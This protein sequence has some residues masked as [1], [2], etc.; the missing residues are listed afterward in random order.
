[1]TQLEMF[2]QI[3]AE[4]NH[5][6]AVCKKQIW[7]FDHWCMAHIIAK[8]QWV[9]FKLYAD[10]IIILCRDCHESYDKKST[11][12]NPLFNFLHEKAD[13]LRQLYSSMN[14]DQRQLLVEKQIVK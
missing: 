10:N 14:K 6:C 4:R 13:S 3:W 7:K 5:E 2:W 9:G 1:M 8:Q 12:N 11:K